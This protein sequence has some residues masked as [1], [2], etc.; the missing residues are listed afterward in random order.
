M[1]PENFCYWLQGCLELNPGQPMSAQQVEMIAQHL[2]LVFEKKTGNLL[3]ELNKRI[4][5]PYENP[6][7]PV[8]YLTPGSIRDYRVTC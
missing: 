5:V 4:N 6:F 8:R 7:E 1:T 2:N 3:D